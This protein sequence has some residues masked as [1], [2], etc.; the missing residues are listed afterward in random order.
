MDRTPRILMCPPDYYGIEYEINPWMNRAVASDSAESHRQWRA[1]YETLD[2]AGGQ[3]RT[4][5]PR[6]RAFPT[7][8][9][10]PTRG[11][12]TTTGSSARGFAM[13]SVR[14][15]RPTS[16]AGRA[17]TGSRSSDLPRGP[18]TSKG[19]AMRSSAARRSSPATGSAAM[20]GATTGSARLWASRSCRSSWSIPGSTT[21]IPASAPWLRTRRSI[22]RAPSTTTAGRCS[23]TAIAHLIAGLGRGGGHLQLQ[24]RGRRPDGHHER[25]DPQACRMRCATPATPS[26]RSG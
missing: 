26:G 2:R 25:G 12:S 11:W 10:R 6:S 18:A 21:S 15:R 8:S 16:S 13:A 14:V 20:P 1:L 17:A 19:R 7:W 23:T 9:S 5:R 22:T 3:G 4:A 24:R